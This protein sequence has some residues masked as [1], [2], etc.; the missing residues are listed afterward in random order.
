MLVAVEIS[1]QRLDMFVGKA[2]VRRLVKVFWM[3]KEDRWLIRDYEHSDFMDAFTNSP[4]PQL[5][6]F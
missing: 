3:K 5:K 2:D 6:G 1:S 4:S